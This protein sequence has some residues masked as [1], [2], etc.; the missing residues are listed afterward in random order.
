MA[1]DVVLEIHEDSARTYGGGRGVRDMGALQSALA[2]PQSGFGE[3]YFHS[4]I[5]EMA[6]A[7]AFHICQNHPFVDGNKRTAL[8]VA[9]IFLR[10]NGYEVKDP[11]R[12]LIDAMLAVASGKSSKAQLAVLLESLAKP[13]TT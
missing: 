3:Q 4:T 7:Y 10:R 8:S 11:G 12:K 1:L 13:K 5:W 6:A 9:L 2:M